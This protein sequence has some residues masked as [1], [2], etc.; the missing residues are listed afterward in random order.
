MTPSIYIQ[1][2]KQS[3][4]F[5]KRPRNPNQLEVGLRFLNPN[6]HILELGSVKAHIVGLLKVDSQEH[7]K[8][9]SCNPSPFS[10]QPV[11]IRFV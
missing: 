2:F 3:F 1:F 6:L 8:P 5:L 10:L 9:Q 4:N 11:A 7:L